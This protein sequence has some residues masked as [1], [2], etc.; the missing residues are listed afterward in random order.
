[1][2]PDPEQLALAARLGSS[3]LSDALDAIGHRHQCLGWDIVRVCGSGGTATAGRAFPLVVEAV[4]A[5]ADVPYTGLLAALDAVGPGDV[6]VI[7][8]DRDVTT[9]VWGELLS[10]ASLARG[11]AGVVTDGMVR[12]VR[13]VD[14][15]DFPVFARGT[16]PTDVDGRL[17]V[18]GHG[19]AA[20][21]DGVTVAPGD[22]VV[23]DEDGVVVVPAA[24]VD[25]VVERASAKGDDEQSFRRAVEDGMLP[26]EA[27]GRY[28]V[29]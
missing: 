16:M 7:P 3:L 24:V 29:L 2:A 25:G 12:D 5:P 22:L 20:S 6:V 4:D 27:Y 19:V 18:V 10:T 1:M 23:A 9:A 8:T 28:G 17:E 21:I 13:Q 15:L 11:A 26:S 14:A